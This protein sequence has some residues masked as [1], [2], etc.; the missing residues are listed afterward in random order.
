MRKLE[1]MRARTGRERTDHTAMHRLLECASY[2]DLFL[3]NTF[4]PHKPSRRW[5]WHSP[6]GKTHNQIDHIM[7][8]KSFR[9]SV[10]INRTRSF[11]GAD[12]GSDHKLL[13]MTFRLRLKRIIKPTNT[14]IKYDPEKLKDPTVA[15]AFQAK[16]DGKFAPLILLENENDV[17]TMITAMNIAVTETANEILGKHRRIKKPWVTSDILDLCDKRR[18]LKKKKGDTEGRERYKKVNTEIR[19]I[20]KKAKEKWIKKQCVSIENNLKNNNT[21]MAYQTVKELTNT[22]QRRVSVIQDKSGKCLTE[23]H[24]VLTRFT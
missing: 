12:V 20:L 9:S 21:K 13:M 15:K 18:E 11:P 2:N 16:I 10:N 3:T 6:N 8:K 22:Q 23:E 17:D 1:Q 5:T 24:E 4:G 14:R 7:V 19:N